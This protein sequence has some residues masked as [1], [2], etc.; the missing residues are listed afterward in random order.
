MR[1]LQIN[2]ADIFAGGEKMSLTLHQ[3]YLELGYES[4]LLVGSKRSHDPSIIEIPCHNNALI[5]RKIWKFLERKTNESHI[6]LLRQ[7]RIQSFLKLICLKPT[8]I[9]QFLS[10]VEFIDY[11]E[12]KEILKIIPF[13]PD[14]IHC[15]S[16]RGYFDLRY[17][18]ALSRDIP[19]VLTLHAPWP[20]TGQ[21]NPPFDCEEWQRSCKYCRYPS[22]IPH[23][24]KNSPE[25]NL[26]VKLEIFSK[27]K[28][29]V[30][31]PSKWLL[32]MAKK[33]ILAPG[34]MDARVIPNGVDK[35]LFKPSDNY[36][37]RRTLGLPDQTPII[38][39]TAQGIQGNQMKDFPTLRTSLII[40]SKLKPGMDVLCLTLHGE[41]SEEKFDSVTLRIFP[42]QK[43]LNTVIRFFQAADIYVHPAR[44]DN[45]PTTIL[46]AMACGK[47]V[48]ASNVSGIP[49]IVD[50]GVT[51]LLVP[52]EDPQALAHAILD[53]LE[54]RTKREAMGVQG[55][56]K[57]VE[58]FSLEKMAQEHIEFYHMMIDA[59]NKQ[60]SDD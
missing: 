56:K 34:I 52:P 20:L 12:S 17:L 19:V 6:F 42:F 39:F 7:Q 54:N 14:I 51:G 55:R 11:P 33:S 57:A 13:V 31:S 50:Q 9:V 60:K 36:S 15:H 25:I 40:L 45:F 38:L 10:G 41:P 46:E 28:V 47:P 3:Q 21:C 27:I 48:I 29:G 18:P 58:Q 24:L 44:S 22:K 35:N 5:R 26:K 2:Y 53:L 8:K 4:I 23:Y 43:D 1:I 32:D 30:I 16:L 37:I 49:E 59:H